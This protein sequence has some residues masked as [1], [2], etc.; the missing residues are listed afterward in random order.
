M[1]KTHGDVEEI[2]GSMEWLIYFVE[3]ALA[4]ALIPFLALFVDADVRHLNVSRISNNIAYIWLVLTVLL[5]L[6]TASSDMFLMGFQ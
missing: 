3:A 4:C 6:R 1:R 2:G 5:W